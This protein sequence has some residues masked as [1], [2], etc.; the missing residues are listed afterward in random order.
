MKI[1]FKEPKHVYF[2]GIGGAN[3][4][5]LASIIMDKGFKVS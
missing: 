2:I 5:S 3:M 1:D 4:S